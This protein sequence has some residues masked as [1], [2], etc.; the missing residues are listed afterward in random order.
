MLETT[1]TPKRQRLNV[2]ARLAHITEAQSSYFTRAQAAASEVGDYEI[3][4]ALRY[5]QI[6]RIDS[7]VYRLMGASVDPHET[8]RAAWLR[9]T[10]DLSPRQRVRQPK[11]WVS[12]RSATV[13]QGFGDFI[14][15]LCEFTSTQRRQPRAN[16]RVTVRTAGLD[17]TEWQV[18][19][20]FVVTTV[21]RT[22][23]DL[24][25]NHHDGGHLGRYAADALHAGATTL[26]DLQAAAPFAPIQA[27]INMADK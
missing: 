3:A 7:G 6:R 19:D 20:G 11:L 24:H 1:T 27:M 25:A 18:L 8:L 4:R 26:A 23:A 17:R 9:Y 21:A 13:L 14:A 12:H 5:E 10:P 15:D 22:F 16:V 2:A